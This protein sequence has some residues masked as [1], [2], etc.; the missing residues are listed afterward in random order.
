MSIAVSELAD[1]FLK[2]PLHECSR[3]ELKQL[4]Q[5]YPYFAPAQL[6]WA[7]KLQQE[8]SSLYAEQVQRTSLYFQNRMWL[9]HLLE[10]NQGINETVIAQPVEE[11]PTPDT[12][13]HETAED[14]KAEVDT[15]PGSI[16]AEPNEVKTIAAPA[17]DDLLS[18]KDLEVQRETETERETGRDN[19]VKAESTALESRVVFEP[20]HTVDYFAS[21]GIRFKDEDRPKDKFGQQLKSFTE[22]L[23]TMKRVPGAENQPAPDANSERKVEQLAEHSL[24]ERHVVTE[25]MA[26]VWLKQGNT[27]KAEEIYRK[28]SLLDPSKSAYFAAK[29]EGLKK[30]S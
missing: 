13:E 26:E 23:K 21:Q 4:V 29:I 27:A 28:L 15:L 30:T 1:L 8:N 6:L 2:K 10:K 11:L 18:N 19:E 14:E 9:N 22:W 20:Y 17:S 5:H 7:K 25:A 12:K 3:D 24:V 16:T